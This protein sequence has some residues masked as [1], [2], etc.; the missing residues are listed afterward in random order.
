MRLPALLRALRPQQWAKN[1]F[2]LAAPVFAYGDRASQIEGDVLGPVLLA[3]AGFC[4]A[5]SA[6]YLFNDV[7]DVE[8]D[9]LHPTKRLRPIAAGEI[10]VPVALGASV[11]LAAL[12]LG[13]GFLAGGEPV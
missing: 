5:A 7:I 2:V 1:L 3:F 12:A 13:A 8:K 11:L 6:V 4:L 9:R 10:S